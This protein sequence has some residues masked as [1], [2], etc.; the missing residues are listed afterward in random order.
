[1]SETR[2]PFDPAARKERISE[3]WDSIAEKWDSWAP[4]VN[5]WFAPAT[6]V[7]LDLVELKSGERVLELAAGTGG[8]T[9]QLARTVGPDG[10]VVATDIGP[11]MVKLLAR[12]ARAAGFANVLARVMDGESPDLTWASMDVVVCRQGFMFFADPAAALE[13]L[14]RI[15]RPSGRIGLTVF[16][17][18]ARNG[19]MAVP[20]SILSRWGKPESDPGPPPSGPGPFS[21]SKPG[22]LEEMLVRAGFIDVRSRMVPSPLRM[23]TNEELLRFHR[24]LLGGLVADLAPAEQERAWGAVA[25]ATRQ[26]TGADSVEA[27]CELLVVS[28]RRPPSP[29]R[30]E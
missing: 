28:G 3:G 23:R 11:N 10:R 20:L 24:D 26:Y 13:R 29:A 2:G 27:P 16:S 12:K 14:F 6:A 7:L 22:Q 21:I 15:L 4:V 9:V 17:T 30:R 19:F 1:M 5:E 25:E 8:L 18:P